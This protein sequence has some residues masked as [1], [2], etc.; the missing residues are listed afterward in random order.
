MKEPFENKYPPIVNKKTIE[1][2]ILTIRDVRRISTAFGMATLYEAL[3]EKDGEVVAF[4]G[5]MVLDKQEIGKGDRIILH[6][7]K[8]KMSEYWIA[9][10]P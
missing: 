9:E 8:G 4:T 3:R 5:G 10:K 6:K 1:D 2:E 7:H